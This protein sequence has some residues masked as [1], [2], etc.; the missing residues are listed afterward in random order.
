VA[1]SLHLSSPDDIQSITM[2]VDEEEEVTLA[3]DC[4]V[5]MLEADS[6]LTVLVT[7]GSA[8][9]GPLEELATRYEEERARNLTLQGSVD[10]LQGSV[11]ELQGS[12]GK[13]YQELEVEKERAAELERQLAAATAVVKQEP[14]IKQEGEAAGAGPRVKRER[15]E[16]EKEEPA[17]S[18]QRVTRSGANKRPRGGAG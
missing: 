18:A 5:R 13:L 15:E 8:G 7:E 6:T 17:G 1:A 4:D 10:Q 9:D 12:V 16:E 2:E 11:S 14:G 3:A